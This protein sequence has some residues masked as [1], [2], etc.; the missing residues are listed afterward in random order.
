MVTLTKKE[1]SKIKRKCDNYYEAVDE[2]MKLQGYDDILDFHNMLKGYIKSVSEINLEHSQK[3]SSLFTFQSRNIL[4]DLTKEHDELIK[5]VDDDLMQSCAKFVD[6]AKQREIIEYYSNHKYTHGSPVTDV[7]IDAYISIFKPY[8]RTV[9][10]SRA[11]IENGYVLPKSK[12]EEIADIWVAKFEDSVDFWDGRVTDAY[13][14]TQQHFA[15]IQKLCWSNPIELENMKSKRTKIRVSRSLSK[16]KEVLIPELYD[17]YIVRLELNYVAAPSC[18]W[19][20]KYKE[21]LYSMEYIL[22][23]TYSTRNYKLHDSVKIDRHNW[24]LF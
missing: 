12:G 8:I 6:D 11:E 2:I 9:E 20:M 18:D 21:V 23:D 4:R 24:Y 22:R 14:C 1:I 7:I 19:K 16:V 13:K 10:I 5:Q 15:S 3:V 17:A